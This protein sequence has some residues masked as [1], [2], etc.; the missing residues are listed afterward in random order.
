MEK[1][2]I[3]IVED[4]IIIAFDIKHSLLKFGYDV[5]HIVSNENDALK[6]VSKQKPDLVLMDIILEGEKT[7]IDAAQKIKEKYGIPLIFLT[8]HISDEILAKAKEIE[9]YGYLIKPF[10]ESEL[11]AILEMT[12]HKIKTESVLKKSEEKHRTLIET[13]EEGL[14]I[15]DEKENFTFSNPA[16]C[17]I[18]GYPEKILTSMNVKDFV[19]KEE[20]QK[21]LENTE[22]RKK[23][24]SS[25]YEMDI[26]TKNNQKKIITI[27][28]SPL[29]V[30]GKFSGTFGI[31]SDITEKKRINKTFREL[32][33]AVETMTIGVTNRRK[34]NFYKSSRC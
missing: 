10:K 14:I 1:K 21:I 32:M 22:L 5:I 24:K 7:G 17:K 20:F 3:L 13:M 19:T 12:F 34:N 16:A 6:S 9:P 23:G 30:D 33:K 29:M 31:I 4:E 11:H 28:A 2:K 8:A 18:F 27:A 15:V 26:F 25:K